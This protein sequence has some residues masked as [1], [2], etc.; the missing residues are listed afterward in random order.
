MYGKLNSIWP[1]RDFKIELFSNT[2]P[3]ITGL[4]KAKHFL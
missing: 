2:L 4:V 3:D 1:N